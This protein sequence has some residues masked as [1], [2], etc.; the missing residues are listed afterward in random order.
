M[1]E[2]LKARLDRFHAKLDGG[3]VV[4]LEELHEGERMEGLFRRW[5]RAL[6]DAAAADDEGRSAAVKAERWPGWF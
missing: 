1:K 4:G 3:E 5:V 2:V 6:E